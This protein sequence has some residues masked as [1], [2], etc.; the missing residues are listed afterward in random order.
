MIIVIGRDVVIGLLEVHYWVVNRLR[1]MP[2]DRCCCCWSLQNLPRLNIA[3][4]SGIF[5]VDVLL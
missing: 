3:G 4:I 1:D 5:R 2:L